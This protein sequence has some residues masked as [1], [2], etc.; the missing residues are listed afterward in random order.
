MLKI[1]ATANF[2]NTISSDATFHLSKP[3]RRSVLSPSVKGDHAF[4]RQSQ[5][6]RSVLSP[7]AKGY[8]A[9]QR[10]SQR[11]R[12]VLAAEPEATIPSGVSVSG[13]HP[14]QLEPKATQH[15]GRKAIGDHPFRLLQHEATLRLHEGIQSDV[16]TAARGDHPFQRQSQ[17]RR[18]VLAAEP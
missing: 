7:S 3:R 13:N 1:E 4:Q 17:R 10:Q 5:R 9:F 15:S 18:S 2:S 11:G 6:R 8:H 14:F 12:S 16:L